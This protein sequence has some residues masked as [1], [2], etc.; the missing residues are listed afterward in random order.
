MCSEKGYAPF[1]LKLYQQY[2]VSRGYV[3]FMLNVRKRYSP[4]TLQRLASHPKCEVRRAAVLSLGFIGDYAVNHTVG[5]A[6]RDDDRNVR[7][8]AEEACRSVWNRAGSDLQ[9]QQL[10]EVVR[11]NA[12]GQYG[13]ATEKASELLDHAPGFAEAWYQKGAAF[14]QL[15]Q[16]GRAIHDFGRAV[17]LNPYQFVAAAALGEAYLRLASPASALGAFRFALRVNPKLE[18]VRVQVAQLASRVENEN[19]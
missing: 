13:D 12:S 2:L 8:L 5:Q 14:F 15:H 18:R 1:L 9:R 3:G 4:S 19:E 7:L 16:F 11:L 6:L 17:E 10:I